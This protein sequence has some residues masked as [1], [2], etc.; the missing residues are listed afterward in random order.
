METTKQ[1]QPTVSNKH[2]E[3]LKRAAQQCPKKYRPAY[4][5]LLEALRRETATIR[6]ECVLFAAECKEI[7]FRQIVVDLLLETP[8]TDPWDMAEIA[9][10]FA[11]F[12][13]NLRQFAERLRVLAELR[14]SGV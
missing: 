1:N 10:N 3:R 2:M 4:I 6:D 9:D 12:V 7:V 5:Y 14:Q 13:P 8:K 11:A